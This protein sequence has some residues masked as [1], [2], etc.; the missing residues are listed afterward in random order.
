M[1]DDEGLFNGRSSDDWLTVRTA[2]DDESRRKAIDAIRHVIEPKKSMSLFF[3]TLRNDSYWRARALAAHA[4]YDLAFDQDARSDVLAVLP[5]L[6]DALSDPSV[7]VRQQIIYIL[8]LLGTAA[9]AAVPR[10][11]E[12][13]H[14]SDRETSEAARN[15]VELIRS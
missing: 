7:Q 3:D 11:E 13:A 1:S 15:A 5:G 12:I 4:N 2:G 6:I 10:L 8:E 9:A 14:E